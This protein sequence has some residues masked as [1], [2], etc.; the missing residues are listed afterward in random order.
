MGSRLGVMKRAAAAVDLS[1]EEYQSKI[2]A[3]YK[4]CRVCKLW[5]Y[6]GRFNK[7]NSRGDG[8][9]PVCR[10][11]QPILARSRYTPRVKTITKGRAFV[12]ARGGDKKQARRRINYFVEANILPAPNTLPCVDC[13]H[14][15][16]DNRRR[17][18]Y[19]H[20]LG[21]DAIHHE[22]VQVVCSRCHHERELKRNDQ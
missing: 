12:P 15:V 13:G 3:G 1:L 19:D 5:K 2:D 14:K 11:C 7:D 22:D 16:G 4:R 8:R 17:H 9:M 20:Y 6:K 18:E 21:Y 10:D